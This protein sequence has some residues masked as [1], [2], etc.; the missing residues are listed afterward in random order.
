MKRLI[1]FIIS[2]VMPIILI[3]GGGMV[4]G[5]GV[6]NN[7]SVITYAG[8]ALIGAGLL[9]GLFLWLWASGGDL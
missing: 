3:G 1:S 4:I 2:L 9:W 6:N 5:L 8:M 7:S